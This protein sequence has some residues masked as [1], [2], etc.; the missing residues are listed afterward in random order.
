MRRAG[1]DDARTV[2][3]LFPTGG[4]A[5]PQVVGSVMKPTRELV[6]SIVR[7][8]ARDLPATLS[9]A[10]PNYQIQSRLVVNDC[11]PFERRAQI[12]AFADARARAESAAAAGV[13]VTYELLP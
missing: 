3:P 5:W 11:G 1:V 10:L 7:K 6:E 9:P 12:A 4:N 13:T 8:V 2:L